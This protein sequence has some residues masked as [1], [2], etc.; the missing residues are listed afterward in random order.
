MDRRCFRVK[1]RG[2]LNL[3]ISNFC[4]VI[5]SVSDMVFGSIH[6]FLCRCHKQIHYFILTLYDREL[7]EKLKV[8]LTC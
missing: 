7:L 1:N 3:N 2:N 6:S 4:A 8:N 5:F